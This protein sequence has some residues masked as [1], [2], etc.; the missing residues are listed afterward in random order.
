MFSS[1]CNTAH[2]TKSIRYSRNFSIYVSLWILKPFLFPTEN[3]FRYITLSSKSY[4]WRL[5]DHL[6][7]DKLL[8]LLLFSIYL[9]C[10]SVVWYSYIVHT[11]YIYNIHVHVKY[12]MLIRT[13]YTT[14][15]FKIIII[16]IVRWY[17]L[18]ENT[19]KTRIKSLFIVFFFFLENTTHQE[20]ARNLFKV[21]FDEKEDT[22]HGDL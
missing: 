16:E 18:W 2:S 13:T 7:S 20:I 9:I 11:T 19:P 10:R 8:L 4:N 3:K 5:W 1:A 15:K 6:S 22:R 21:S 14:Y 17:I 12:S